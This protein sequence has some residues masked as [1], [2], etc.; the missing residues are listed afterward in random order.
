M[1]KRTST[2]GDITTDLDKRVHRRSS[3]ANLDQ[4]LQD[5]MLVVGERLRNARIPHNAK[6][7]LILP[8]DH[9]VLN[10]LS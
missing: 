5:R 1:L 7:Q 9:N 2:K 6:H 3:I 10:D 4:E 8:K